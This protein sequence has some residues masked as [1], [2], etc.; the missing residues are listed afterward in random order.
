MKVPT[1]K[2]PK[3]CIAISKLLC[4][5]SDLH[6]LCMSQGKKHIDPYCGYNDSKH[7]FMYV[8]KVTMLHTTKSL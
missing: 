7:P 2:W 1:K 5:F 6:E 4:T 8:W 3:K